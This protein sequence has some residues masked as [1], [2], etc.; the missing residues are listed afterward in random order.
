MEIK[1][2][3]INEESAR[4][5]HE[6]MSFRDYVPGSKTAEYRGYVDRAY[7]LADEAAKDRPDEADRIYALVDRYAKRLADN[8]NDESRIGCMCPSIMIAGGSNFPVRKKE[9]QNAAADRNRQEWNEIQN[10]LEKIKSIRNG[11]DII[12]SGDADALEKL[13][14]KLDGLKELQ[15][16]MKA[17]NAAI[18]LKD[19]EKGDARMAELGYTAE[20]IRELREPDFCGRVG[21]PSYLLSN[22]NANIHR[23]EARIK[24]LTAAKAAEPTE[25]EHEG[26]RVVENTETMR[27][28]LFFD[29]KPDEET[30]SILKSNGFRWAPSVGAWQRQLTENARSALRRIISQL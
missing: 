21:F 1:Y 8:L 4:R 22:N 7:A 25:T 27:L 6:M 10:I 24:E 17:A 30:R 18:R 20:Q 15:E 19:T 3:E 5:A 14:K 28:Q 2:Y 11:K 12:K 16:R 23:I 26:F 9:K 13:Q 29:G